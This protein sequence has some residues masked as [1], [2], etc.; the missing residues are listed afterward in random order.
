MG[1]IAALLFSTG[2]LRGE[3]H[4]PI[5]VVLAALSAMALGTV[6]GGWRIVHTMGS[7]VTHLRPVGGSCGRGCSRF[8]PPR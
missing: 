6:A 3:S 4:V 7:R 1:I 5:W 2:D 8:R